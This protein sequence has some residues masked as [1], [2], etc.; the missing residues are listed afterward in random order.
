MNPS[1]EEILAA[2]ESLGTDKVIVLPNN[3]NIIMAAET[4]CEMASKEARVVRTRTV[5]QG[6]NALLSLDPDGELDDVVAAMTGASETVATGEITTATRNVTLGGVQVQDGHILGLSNGEV[7]SAGPDLE[8]VVR[9]TLE[10]MNIDSRE[11]LTFYYGAE[12][13]LGAA[14]AMAAKAQEWHPEVEVEVVDGGQPH[15][16]YIISAE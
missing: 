1:T 15:Y 9:E 8:A 10:N 13:K 3:K 4:A 5:P 14:K 7:C 2:I 16:F 6:V 12:I 11:L